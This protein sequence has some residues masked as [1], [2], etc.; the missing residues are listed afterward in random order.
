MFLNRFIKS[1]NQLF[2]TLVVIAIFLIGVISTNQSVF[3]F[4]DGKKTL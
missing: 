3:L 4:L 1:P 2:F